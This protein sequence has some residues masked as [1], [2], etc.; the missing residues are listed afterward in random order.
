MKYFY[1][2]LFIIITNCSLDKKNSFWSDNS[3]SFTD[4]ILVFDSTMATNQQ[5]DNKLL[6]EAFKK[7]NDLK[8]MTFKDFNLY[9]KDYS[10]N[11]DYPDINN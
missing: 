7:E 10:N 2:F 8:S 4:Y 5:V 11:A 9:L 1:F 6:S 3:V